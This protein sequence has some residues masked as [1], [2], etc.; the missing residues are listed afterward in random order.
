M[1][2]SWELRPWS[3]RDSRF[4]GVKTELVALSDLALVIQ[5][6][7]EQSVVQTRSFS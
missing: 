7:Q 2:V 5:E 1:L 6:G 3:A 4:Q